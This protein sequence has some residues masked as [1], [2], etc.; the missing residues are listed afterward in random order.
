[1]LAY[2]YIEKGK[3]ALVE[4]PKPTL[5]ESTDAIVRVTMSS[6]CT[7]DL[8]IKHGSVPRVVPGITV[9]HEMVGVVEEVGSEVTN[10]KPGDRVTVNVETFC[11]QLGRSCLPNPSTPGH[12]R[13][14]RWGAERSEGP[15]GTNGGLGI[16][17]F[18][19]PGAGGG[20]GSLWV[21][22]CMPTG[23]RARDRA[24]VYLCVYSPASW[25]ARIGGVVLGAEGS[26]TGSHLGF[27]SLWKTW[28]APFS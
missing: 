25:E 17:G 7:S 14:E 19:P 11:C 16:G 6:I 20:A 2:T 28:W 27:V 9:G 21:L 3:F 1:M 24:V 4:K 23:A 22:I 13:G 15:G 8:H 18:V 10:V 26:R 5:I 12:S